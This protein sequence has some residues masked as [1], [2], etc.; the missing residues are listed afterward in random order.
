MKKTALVLLP[1][2]LALCACESW[3]RP[4]ISDGEAVCDEIVDAR[5][6]LDCIEANEQAE[7]NWREEKKREAAEKAK[8]QD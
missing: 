8:K 3:N 6:R 7:D 2:L 1:S 4:Y 5:A